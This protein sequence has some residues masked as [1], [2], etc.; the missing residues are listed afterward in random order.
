MDGLLGTK[1]GLTPAM[2]ALIV[3]A[4]SSLSLKATVRSAAQNREGG[5]GGGGTDEEGVVIGK[6]EGDKRVDR[7]GYMN[8]KV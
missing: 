1:V 7:N 5:K 6:W 4:S 2:T 8:L 3:A